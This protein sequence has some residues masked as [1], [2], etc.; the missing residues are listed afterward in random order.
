MIFDNL[1]IAGI[2]VIV[3]YCLVVYALSGISF[4]DLLKRVWKSSRLQHT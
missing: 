3:C 1:T 4:V 2:A